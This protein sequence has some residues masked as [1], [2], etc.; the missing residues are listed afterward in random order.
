MRAAR[1]GTCG[2]SFPGVAVT[3]VA[4]IVRPAESDDWPKLRA[5]RLEALTD[6]P[7]AFGST[8]AVAAKLSNYQWR[9][10]IERS[11][12]FLAER[13]GDVVGMVSGGLNDR[14]PGT[15]WLYGMYV[16]PVAR[17]TQTASLL[18]DVVAAWARDEGATELYLHVTS[19]AERAR[20]FYARMGFVAT[21][22]NFGMDRDPRLIMM[23]L[24]KS[25]VD[26]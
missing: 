16:T 21:G 20:A 8:Y 7:E 12:Y 9:S 17:G 3:D 23:T 25:L 5:I 24:K 11:L 1:I 19:I 18:V 6:A 14:H 15:H 22:V 10:M 13:D 26:G 4:L 2:G